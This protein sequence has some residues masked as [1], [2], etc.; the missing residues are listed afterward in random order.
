MNSM[1]NMRVEILSGLV[2]LL[3]RMPQLRPGQ[4]LCNLACF[5]LT[6]THAV[7]WTISDDEL[8]NAIREHRD[9]FA[10]R[11]FAQPLECDPAVRAEFFETFEELAATAPEVPIGLLLTHL[12]FTARG[13]SVGMIWEVED[14][15]LL[16]AA[17][18]QLE[19]NR[20]RLRLES[21]ALAAIAAYPLWQS[22]PVLETVE[23]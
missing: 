22:E 21:E 19:F 18:Q 6:E 2:E 3:D 16:R 13:I 5:T 9:Q 17:Q 23:I 8:L 20:H 7:A 15:E 12:A 10:N 14:H 1:N 11:D 4:L